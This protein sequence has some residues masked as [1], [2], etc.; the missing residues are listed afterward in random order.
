MCIRDR[1]TIEQGIASQAEIEAAVRLIGGDPVASA[2]PWL[3]PV[4]E[5]ESRRNEASFIREVSRPRRFDVGDTVS[6]QRDAPHAGHHRLPRYA[7]G[8]I[9]TIARCYPAF[10]FPDSVAHGNGESPQ[11]VYAVAFTGKELWGPDSDDQLV[12]HLDLFEPYL[13]ASGTDPSSS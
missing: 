12:C 5:L 9:G 13:K 8:R 1:A 11:Y 4:T 2:P 10:T 7:R 3:H 6:T